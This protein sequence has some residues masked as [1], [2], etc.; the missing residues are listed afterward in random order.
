MVARNFRRYVRH[1]LAACEI[2]GERIRKLLVHHKDHNPRNDDP[3]NLQTLCNPCHKM[4][5]GQLKSR[6][7]TYSAGRPLEIEGPV[8]WS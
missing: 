7:G 8:E 4:V 2:C 3:T 5:H 1:K 6:R